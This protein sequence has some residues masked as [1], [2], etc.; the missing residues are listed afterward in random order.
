M[1]GYEKSKIL[2]PLEKYS[3]NPLNLISMISKY[4]KSIDIANATI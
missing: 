2:Y 4:P 1:N 3:F